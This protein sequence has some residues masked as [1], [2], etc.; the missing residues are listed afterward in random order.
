MSEDRDAIITYCATKPVV[1]ADTLISMQVELRELKEK[2]D[3]L[4]K[5]LE[6]NVKQNTL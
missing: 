5:D 1:A 2:H 6:H 4:L 3:K